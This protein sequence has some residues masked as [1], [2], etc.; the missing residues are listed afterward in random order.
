MNVNLISLIFLFVLILYLIKILV[1]PK[2]R[3]QLNFKT[4]FKHIFIIWFQG[5]DNMPEICKECY[6]SW[7]YKNKDW[8]IHF[9]DDSNIHRYID[10]NKLNKFK[11]IKPLQCYADAV[12]LELIYKYGGLYVDATIFCNKPLDLWLNDNLI[13]NTFVQWDYDSYLPSINFLYTNK[14]K[15]D[16]FNINVNKL[17]NSYHK[18]NNIFVKKISSLKKNFIRKQE[19][20]FGKSSNNTRPKK[21][22]KLISNSFRLMNQNN[23]KNF[24]NALN[25]YPFFKLT[26]KGVPK[27]DLNNVFNKKSKLIKLLNYKK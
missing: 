2:I 9:I 14:L 15:N 3:E 17:D 1:K 21:G 12:R 25:V 6:N 13:D 26:H 23:D 19:D 8:K 4:D 22:V 10:D 27:G 20:S 24:N 18:I 16:Y 7:K 11:K 5:F